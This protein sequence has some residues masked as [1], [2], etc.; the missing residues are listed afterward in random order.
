MLLLLLLCP[1]G[2][3]CGFVWEGEGTEQRMRWPQAV[4]ER[5]STIAAAAALPKRHRLRIVWEGE[6]VW[7][8]RR[9]PEVV[10]T[11]GP[12]CCRCCRP[13]TLGGTACDLSKKV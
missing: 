7:Q 9:W 1:K 12:C 3:A 11:R 8:R 6:G 13:L 4:R 2:I 5:G 10:C